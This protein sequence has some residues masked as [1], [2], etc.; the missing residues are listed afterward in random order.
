MDDEESNKNTV[1]TTDD[2]PESDALNPLESQPEEKNPLDDD[3]PDAAEETEVAK[4]PLNEE[5]A[6]LETVSAATATVQPPFVNECQDDDEDENEA[7]NKDADE[8][9]NFKYEY[10][11]FLSLNSAVH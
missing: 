7:N 2:Q 6:L 5:D 11:I 10:G 4:E 3:E 1:I 8:S 9:D